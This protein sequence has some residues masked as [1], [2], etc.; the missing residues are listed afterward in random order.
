M[1]HVL[2]GCPD[3]PCEGTILRGKGAAS[4]EVQGL[5]AMSRVKTAEPTDMPFGMW[6][7]VGPGNHV[8]VKF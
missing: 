2:D 5:S 6:T 8:K 7:G 1:N 3:P 4:C